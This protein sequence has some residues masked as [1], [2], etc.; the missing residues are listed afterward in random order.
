MSEPT[1]PFHDHNDRVLTG[2]EL[3]LLTGLSAST[4]RREI[5]RGRFPAPLQLSPGRCAHTL[6]QIKEWQSEIRARTEAAALPKRRGG[7]G[8]PRKVGQFAK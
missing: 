1:N 6:G 3:N 8:R 2:E 4:I 5:K 7:P